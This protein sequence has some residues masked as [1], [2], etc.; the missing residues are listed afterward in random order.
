MNIC[1]P[2][3]KIDLFSPFILF[4]AEQLMFFLSQEYQRTER[5]IADL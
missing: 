5:D 4:T 1:H 2:T 3:T